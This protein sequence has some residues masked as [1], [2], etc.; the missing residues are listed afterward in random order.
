MRKLWLS[1]FL[2]A[3]LAA[4]AQSVQQS[5]NVT[6]GHAA[7]WAI[8]GVVYDCGAPGGG[9]SVVGSTT[10][11]DFAAFN[12]SGSLIDSGINPTATSS[13]TGLQNFNGGA[14]FSTATFNGPVTFSGEAFLNGGMACTTSA[15]IAPCVTVLQAP[16]SVNVAAGNYILNSFITGSDTAVVQNN[17]QGI[18]LFVGQNFG[19]ASMTGNRTALNTAINQLAQTG[20]G[21]SGIVG[22]YVASVNT[23]YGNFPDN[24]TASCN[25][26]AP[27]FCRGALFGGTSTVE[28]HTGA[29]YWSGVTGLEVNVNFYAGASAWGKTGIQISGSSTDVNQGLGYDAGLA[30][31]N[32]GATGNTWR[33]GIRFDDLAGTGVAHFPISS[34][35]TIIYAGAASSPVANG[36]DFSNLSAISGC[37]FKSPGNFCVDG[38][39]QLTSNPAV[40]NSGLFIKNSASG[41]SGFPISN[42]FNTFFVSSDNANFGSVG[43]LNALEAAYD[44]GGPQMTGSRVAVGAYLNQTAI[45]SASS[46]GRNYV[47]LNGTV[48]TP[49]GD[50]G[51]ALTLLGS[52]GNYFGLTGFG[53]LNS[54]A[55]NV[56]DVTGGE[57][58][59]AAQTGSST[60]YKT[61][62]QVVEH[63][64]DTV[65]ATS[66]DAGIAISSQTG[67]VGFRHGIVFTDFGS[68]FPIRSTGTLIG[69]SN[70]NSTSPAGADGVDMTGGV[71]SDCAFKFGTSFCVNTGGVAVAGGAIVTATGLYA[72]GA[73]TP[74][75]STVGFG[76]GTTAAGSGNCP[77]GTVGG[78]SVAGCINV[79]VGASAQVIPYF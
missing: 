33:N 55:V 73:V 64:S 34:T 6:P 57:F 10:Q 62:I 61:G 39:G 43:Y 58:N 78:K 63:A 11:N 41:S 20:N 23:A 12:G 75:A 29:L 46:V 35:G 47:A 9:V 1:L 36:I 48:T 49:T 5:G 79:G 67:A 76:N 42:S 56:F 16:T 69:L 24:G 54:G 51:S 27:Q 32:Q 28:L 70:P 18:L 66:I 19:G 15:S 74:T 14:T 50:G 17:Q 31:Y 72:A 2:L 4:N 44:F 68:A 52:L 45:T 38:T 21:P 60:F 71:F 65:S 77:S 25:S 3:P 7:C 22:N 37:A 8:T 53:V 30:F 59:V 13:W 26:G 40:N